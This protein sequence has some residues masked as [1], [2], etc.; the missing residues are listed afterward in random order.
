MPVSAR[1]SAWLSGGCRTFGAM[2]SRSR[3]HHYVPRLLLRSFATTN[4]QV[5]TIDLADGRSYVQAVG[6]AAAE[7]DYNTVTLDSGE[8]D[9]AEQ[10][11][12]A[13]EGEAAPALK[14][15]A[16]GGWFDSEQ[17]RAAVARFMTFQY[18]RVPLRREWNDGLA[19]QLAKLEIA[20]QGPQVLREIGLQSVDGTPASDQE[21]LA[22]WQTLAKFDWKVSAPREHH[23]AQELKLAEEFA[24]ILFN[25]YSWCVTRYQRR[26]LVTSDAP[27][28]LFPGPGHPEWS[29]VGLATA[30]T[31]GFA[32]GRRCCLVLVNRGVGELPHG[33][34]L[35]PSVKAARD[36]NRSSA[37]CAR[38]R[39][40]HHPDDDHDALFGVDFTLPRPAESVLED[41]SGD[42]R[43]ALAKAGEHHFRHPDEPH[44]L[45]GLPP[46]GPPPEGARSFPRGR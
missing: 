4:Q 8:S 22:A 30:G 18:L 28:M 12:S 36:F 27:V 31:I 34:A 13:I 29:G 25:G 40:Y 39:L 46:V 44:P 10:L 11:A 45:S 41:T 1:T 14:R 9:I 42:L 35:P 32:V 38:R 33:S 6:S 5:A 3:K 21:I 7:N 17:E 37:L 26:S 43:D 15:I 20:A 23:V 2:S 19:D 24:P 16:A